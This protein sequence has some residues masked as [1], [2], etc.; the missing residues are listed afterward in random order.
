VKQKGDG[1]DE[2]DLLPGNMPTRRGMMSILLRLAVK[3]FDFYQPSISCLLGVEG[4][5]RDQLQIGGL[6]VKDAFLMAN[7]EEPVQITTKAG[8]FKVMKN[9]PGQ[10]LAAKAWYEFLAAFLEK[11][12]VEFSKEN[13]CLGKRNGSLFI[14][15]HV[16]DM[17]F[18]GL[19]DEVEKLINELKT[20][21]TFLS[22]WPSFLETSLS[23]SSEPM[24]YV[25]MES[26]CC[27]EDML[28][29]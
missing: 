5:S 17:M 12:G 18:C 8:K 24:N 28:R 14:L 22:M 6:D 29:Q 21:F 10:R 4:V 19:K 23:S 9:L 2:L 1:C 20:A 13:P 16:D 15:L 27:P 7:Q 25:K 3:F 26:M 11:R